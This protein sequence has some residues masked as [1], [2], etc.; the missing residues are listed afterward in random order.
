MVDFNEFREVTKRDLN[1]GPA[2]SYTCDGTARRTVADTENKISYRG[3]E[4]IVIIILYIYT[5]VYTKRTST[6]LYNAR[7]VFTGRRI[8]L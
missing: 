2:A 7:P 8:I 1:A 6:Y 5:C 4:Y 3:E